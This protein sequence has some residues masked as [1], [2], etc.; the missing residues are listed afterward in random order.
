MLANAKSES[1]ASLLPTFFLAAIF[2]L[3]SLLSSVFFYIINLFLFLKSLLFQF[4]FSSL[5]LH[6]RPIEHCYDDKDSPVSVIKANGTESVKLNSF[7]ILFFCFQIS[8]I[9]H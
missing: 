5:H 8:I 1:T 2:L 4:L 9:F 7:C 6:L 3:N